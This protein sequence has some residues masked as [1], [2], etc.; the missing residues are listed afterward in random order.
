MVRGIFSIGKHFYQEL[1]TGIISFDFAVM[2][3]GID[4]FVERMPHKTSSKFSPRDNVYLEFGLFSGF[5]SANRV[6][7]LIHE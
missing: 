7:F 3:G 5:L 4:D 2:I 6:L 1:I